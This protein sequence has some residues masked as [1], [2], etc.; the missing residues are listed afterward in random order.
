MDTTKRNASAAQSGPNEDEDV[1]STFDDPGFQSG[2]DYDPTLDDADVTGM[3]DPFPGTAEAT[4]EDIDDSADEATVDD[5]PPEGDGV[6][7]T[8]LTWEYE[9]IGMRDE[10]ARRL[11]ELVVDVREWAELED[12]DEATDI[13]ES[14]ADLYER[15]GAPTESTDG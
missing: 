8:P 7:D 15:L 5:D 2:P 11:G 12:T 3:P 14:L 9:G 13:A 4:P 1:G 10:L 6:T